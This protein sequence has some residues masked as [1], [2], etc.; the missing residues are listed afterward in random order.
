MK[1]PKPVVWMLINRFY[2]IIGGAELQAEQLCRQLIQ[3][4]DIQPTVITRRIDHGMK[5]AAT[6]AGIAIRRLRPVG[7][8]RARNYLA[9]IRVFFYLLRHQHEFDLIHA[10]S[11]EHITL[12]AL[13]AS[14]LV[15]FP[16]ICKV[17]TAGDV[18]RD[19]VDEDRLPLHVRVIRR[20]L[21]VSAW[22]PVLLRQAGAVI[23]VSREIEDD[24]KRHNLGS[25]TSTIPNGVDTL[26]FCPVNEVAK[27]ALRQKLGYPGNKKLVLFSGRLVRRKGVDILLQAWKIVVPSHPDAMLVIVGSGKTQA[28]SV[29][30][31]LQQTVKDSR[32]TD[33]VR[34]MG[35]VTN[36]PEH[37]RVADCFILPSRREG[38]P[39]SVLEAMATGLPVIAT[40]IGGVTDLISHEE[41]GLLFDVDDAYGLAALLHSLLENSTYGRKLGEA[42]LQTVREAYSMEAVADQYHE[43]YLKLLKDA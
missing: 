42:A 31:E 25:L 33:S 14:K 34:F 15:G 5:P 24:L 4:H 9:M 8:G 22:R 39:N 2:P 16:V 21:R 37:L 11:V 41:N 27:S 28:D 3:R 7:I 13:V 38:L 32:L 19:I 29:E 36:V 20:L 17:P 43:L 35:N 40:R 18:T 10:H 12:G 1:E 23:A 6:H 30:Q 26:R